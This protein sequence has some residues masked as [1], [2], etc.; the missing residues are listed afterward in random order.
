MAQEKG[1]WGITYDWYGSCK[2][3]RCLTTPYWNW[4]PIYAKIAQGVIDETYKPGCDYFDADTG[5][6]G[7]YGFMEGQTLTKGVADLPPEVHPE[8]Q[9]HAGADAGGRVHPLRRLLRPDQ[10]Q[11]GQGDRS[12]R[13]EV[14]EQADLDQFR[15]ESGLECKYCMYWWAE[16]I[17]AELPNCSSLNA[18]CQSVEVAR[19]IEVDEPRCTD[20][21]PL[22]PYR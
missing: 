2:V 13:R 19:S 16:G 7:L 22:Q 10:G 3:E 14:L 12:G 6:L 15:P 11:H 9:G 4:G 21:L 18:R 8:G 5:A 17:T 20:P 1:K